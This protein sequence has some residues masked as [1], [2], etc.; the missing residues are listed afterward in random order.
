MLASWLTIQRW[1]NLYF[2]GETIVLLVKPL[3]CRLKPSWMFILWTYSCA[4]IPPNLRSHQCLQTHHST[5]AQRR[6]A[7]DH[8]LAVSAGLWFLHQTSAL[9]KSE[10]AIVIH[11]SDTQTNQEGA[12]YHEC[13]L[14][15]LDDS[16]KEWVSPQPLNN[17]RKGFWGTQP[18]PCFWVFNK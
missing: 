17:G 11:S 1:Q 9:E 7:T 3:F 8:H 12:L 2:A 4:I 15:Y 5:R 16:I 18:V 14:T 13:I 6:D 10:V